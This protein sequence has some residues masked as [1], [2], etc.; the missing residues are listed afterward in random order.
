M[1][2]RVIVVGDVFGQY[3][4]LRE[5]E[6]EDKVYYKRQFEVEC[7]NGLKHILFYTYLV[8]CPVKDE[9]CPYCRR[10]GRGKIADKVTRAILAK[11]IYK[12]WTVLEPLGRYAF[13]CQCTCGR[14][15]EILRT[16][17]ARGHFPHCECTPRVRKSYKTYIHKDCHPALG[18]E[19]GEM[20]AVRYVNRERQREE[21]A[22]ERSKNKQST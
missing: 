7:T 2:R 11:K 12:N 10:I 15:R 3:T 22:R 6:L 14:Q 17:F 5:L 4:V 20:R 21:E 16:Y 9:T 13:L 19:T 1:A 8:G 18:P